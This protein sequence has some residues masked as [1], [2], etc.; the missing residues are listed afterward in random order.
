MKLGTSRIRINAVLDISAAKHH[1]W[2]E[3]PQVF[4]GAAGSAGAAEAA[5]QSLVSVWAA[6]SS[7]TW[8]VAAGALPGAA[9]AAGA[10]AGAA[11]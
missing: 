9:I 8:K 7:V 10:A 6:Q 4:A 1:H 3:P 2:L 11:A 5:A